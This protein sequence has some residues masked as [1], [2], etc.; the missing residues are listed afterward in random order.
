M[1][2]VSKWAQR[3]PGGRVIFYYKGEDGE[4]QFVYACFFKAFFVR[5]EVLNM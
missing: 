3:H 2:D 4:R 1:Y 5:E